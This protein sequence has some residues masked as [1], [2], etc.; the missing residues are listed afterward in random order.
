MMDVLSEMIQGLP[1]SQVV[2]GA[3]LGTALL[4]TPGKQ[5]SLQLA[6]VARGAVQGAASLGR[7]E[8][9]EAVQGQEDPIT[10]LEKSPGFDPEGFRVD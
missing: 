1:V 2:L 3:M 4:Q 9:K 5:T 10:E 6:A 7:L 8:E